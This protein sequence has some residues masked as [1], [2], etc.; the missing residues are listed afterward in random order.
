MV[1]MI[2][3]KHL[4][5]WPVNAKEAERILRVLDWLA[6]THQGFWTKGMR[7]DYEFAAKFLER[8]IVDENRS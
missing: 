7:K 2:W 8:K 6:T 1:W 5:S 3:Q 4:W